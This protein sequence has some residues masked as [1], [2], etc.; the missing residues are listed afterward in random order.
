MSELPPINDPNQA[1]WSAPPPPQFA[2]Y[3]RPGIGGNPELLLALCD[4]Y[5]GFQW[6]FLGNVLVLVGISGAVAF[7]AQQAGMTMA[8][9]YLIS[10]TITGIAVWFFSLKPA[11]QFAKG[12]G[13][14]LS[15]RYLTASVLALQSWFCCG[16]VGYAII[17]N[18]ALTEMKKYGIRAGFFGVKRKDVV[19]LVQQMQATQVVPPA[20]G[21]PPPSIPQ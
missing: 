4:S 16:I 7:A 17:Q 20:P 10:Y 9:V 21:P 6:V 14:P 8:S 3:T 11:G 18:K 5:F 13:R 15:S 1:N 19:A 2:G 12:M